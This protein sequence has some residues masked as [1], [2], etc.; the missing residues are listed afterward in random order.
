M[1]N[2]ERQT[3]RQKDINFKFLLEAIDTVH[4]HIC[5]YQKHYEYRTW[6]QRTLEVVREAEKISFERSGTPPT[7]P[8]P[9]PLTRT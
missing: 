2:D 8:S 7:P 5:K 4:Q 9:N 1:T 6:Q 3:D